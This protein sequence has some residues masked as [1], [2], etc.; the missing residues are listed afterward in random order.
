[1]P[2][3]SIIFLIFFFRNLVHLFR[4]L[5]HVSLNLKHSPL[6]LK[7]KEFPGKADE[8][9]NRSIVVAHPTRATR[10]FTLR[11]CETETRC[12]KCKQNHF[13][14]CRNKKWEMN[15]VKFFWLYKMYIVVYHKKLTILLMPFA[16][17]KMYNIIHQ[18]I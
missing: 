7:I 10:L 11:H 8:H 15:N 14:N 6:S 3:N 18:V 16:V 4:E 12:L 9:F 1:M 17:C 2:G 5:M 13:I